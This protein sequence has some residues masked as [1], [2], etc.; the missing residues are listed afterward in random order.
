VHI[1]LKDMLMMTV[2]VKHQPLE[3][4]SPYF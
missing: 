4:S 3:A 1:T 2:V